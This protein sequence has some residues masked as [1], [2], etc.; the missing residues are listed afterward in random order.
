MNSA[1]IEGYAAIFG[2]PDDNGDI[3]RPGAFR[4]SLIQRPA[5]AV[6]MLYQHQADRP[7]G[8]WRRFREDERGLYAEGEVS[9]ASETGREVWSLARFGALDGLSIG[10]R[11]RRARALRGG[12]ELL[13]VDLWEVS[14]VTF[15]MA[16]AARL[17]AIGE[18]DA[19]D[20]IHEAASRLKAAMIR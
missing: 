20:A 2:E 18:P 5:A 7:I 6:R 13:A 8:R 16:P 12:R 1:S 14:L 9:L 15:P 11:T 17:T 3:I 10:F 4:A 19:A